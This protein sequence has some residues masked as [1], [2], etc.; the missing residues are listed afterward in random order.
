M[1]WTE[2]RYDEEQFP[3]GRRERKA[4]PG[5]KWRILE[6]MN[7][8]RRGWTQ[9]RIHPTFGLEFQSRP[10]YVVPVPPWGDHC[11]VEMT[12]WGV[13]EER[14]P[15]PGP[16]NISA[17]IWCV[18]CPKFSLLLARI[19]KDSELTARALPWVAMV[20]GQVTDGACGLYS[21]DP[22]GQWGLRWGQVNKGE[23]QALKMPNCTLSTTDA[24]G[25]RLGQ[26]ESHWRPEGTEGEAQHS[27]KEP[28]P[29][30]WGQ[31]AF[32]A[33]RLCGM[34]KG[35]DTIQKLWPPSWALSWLIAPKALLTQEKL[36]SL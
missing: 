31:E 3:T 10:H 24:Q 21:G 5:S 22:E 34:G 4:L 2:E 36:S 1:E 30:L 20:R 33:Q 12:M 29:L 13:Q 35:G 7:L 17:H 18:R 14:G 16:L 28:L 19:E 25:Q 23:H 15:D 11:R 27:D 8:R 26:N 6:R 32:R 9:S